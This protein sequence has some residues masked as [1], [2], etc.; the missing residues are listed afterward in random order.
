MSLA[1]KHR[2]QTFE[3]VI[4]Q[5]HITDI[6]KQQIAQNKT[7]NHNYLFFGPRWT[8][9]TTCARILSKAIN[10][11]NPKDWDPCNECLNCQTINR[12]TTLDYVEIDAASH[13]WVDNVR[14]EIIDKVMYPPTQLTKKVYVIDEVHMLSKG[15]FNALL[16]TIE[17]PRPNACFILATTEIHKV[18]DTIISRCQ[19]YNYKK[20]LTDD[21]TKHLENICQKES[22][23]Y[24]E[25]ALRIISKFSE[26]CVRDAVKYVDQVSILWEINEENITKFLGVASDYVI[27]NFITTLK[28]QD[29]NLIFQQVESLQEQWVDLYQ[30]AKQTLLDRKSVV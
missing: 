18:P 8:W 7:S 21:M 5:K 19:V 1:N 12:S 2:P 10:C 6:L 30:F 13:T 20:I 9:K 4:W 22:L 23:K 27:E 29:K 24:T 14:E 11:L 25:K 26:W 16:K 28:T 15:A 17:E 3:Q